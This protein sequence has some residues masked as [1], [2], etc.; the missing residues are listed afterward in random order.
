MLPHNHPNNPA[1]TIRSRRVFPLLA[2]IPAASLGPVM[3][4]GGMT[5]WNQRSESAWYDDASR[6]R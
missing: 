4:S 1:P 3:V 2:T 6:I 5:N